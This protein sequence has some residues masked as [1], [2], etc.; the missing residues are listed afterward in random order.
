MNLYILWFRRILFSPQALFQFSSL[1]S[2]FGLVLAVASLTVALLA[3]N[4][5]SAGLEL[6]LIDRQGHI[7][8]QSESPSS[9]EELWEE[10]S[11]YENQI[12][13]EV[14]FLSFEALLVKDKLF[15]GVLFEAIEDEKLKELS[16]FKKRLLEGDLE[17]GAEHSII[18]GSELGKILNLSVG[19]QVSVISAQSEDPLFSRQ[20]AEFQVAGVIDF[21]RHDFNSFFALMPLSSAKKMG[22]DKIS[23]VKLWLKD[24][25]QSFSLTRELSQNLSSLYSVQSWRSADPVFFEIIQSDKK[26]IFFVLIVL[27]ISAGFN[28]SSSLFT[29][30]FRRTKEINI[31]KALGIEN[32][33]LRNLFLLNGLVLGC[34]G[35][36]L[37]ILLGLSACYLLVFIQNKWYII[38]AQTYQIHEIVWRWNDS[39]LFLIFSL[40]LLVI[41]LSSI[42]PARRACK[43]NIK[44]ALS[45]D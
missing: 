31:L 4:S 34:A 17:S 39:D 30:V 7:L 22:F 13:N 20:Q 19:S 10:L 28:I 38:P 2:L 25:E 27:V 45:Y 15:K 35:V 5:F 8:V 12:E 18:I 32:A 33:R 29:Q 16:F 11:F 3:V 40:S 23:G 43:I 41:V 14:F 24:K 21:G 9:K 1:F 6:V 42:L 37:G 44:Q 36:F 26:I